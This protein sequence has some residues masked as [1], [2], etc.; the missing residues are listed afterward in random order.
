MAVNLS[1]EEAIT[2]CNLHF[3]TSYQI[4]VIVLDEFE[5]KSNIKGYHSCMNIWK[6]IIG[7]NLQTC[8][9]LRI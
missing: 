1:C 6:P 9:N 8:Q 2:I 5:A 7:E 4:P 3:L